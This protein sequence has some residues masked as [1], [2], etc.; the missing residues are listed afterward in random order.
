MTWTTPC[1]TGLVSVSIS[2]SFSLSLHT[3]LYISSCLAYTQT[4]RI[5]II[6]IS[7]PNFDRPST[8]P[9]L[10]SKCPPIQTDIQQFESL[11]SRKI[12][13]HQGK[14]TPTIFY[15]LYHRTETITYFDLST[16]T[17]ASNLWQKA[18]TLCIN[19][20]NISFF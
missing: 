16:V 10:S 20:E 6:F 3:S 7:N 1:G 13:V 17:A 18:R 14:S 11:I 5:H 8:C 4:H 12:G 2:A 9:H 19:K 15:K